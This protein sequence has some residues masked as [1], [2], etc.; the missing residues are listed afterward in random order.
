MCVFSTFLSISRWLLQAGGSNSNTIVLTSDFVG[1]NDLP[2]SIVL[3]KG[4]S[5]VQNGLKGII[6][7]QTT[8]IHVFY[9]PK[10]L[11]HIRET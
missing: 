11:C 5:K 1:I 8:Y 10:T 7:G 3:V 2:F 4:E 9:A 6:K